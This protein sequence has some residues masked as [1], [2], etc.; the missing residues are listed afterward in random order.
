MANKMDNSVALPSEVPVMPLLG[1]VLFP[2]ALLPLY[3]FESHIAR[4]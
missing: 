4:C 1:A 2:H 3:I